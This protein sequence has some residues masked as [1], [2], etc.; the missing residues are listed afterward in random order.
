MCDRHKVSHHINLLSCWGLCAAELQGLGELIVKKWDRSAGGD[1]F[2]WQQMVHS[3][4]LLIYL[5]RL[6][7]TDLTAV[8]F[9]VFFSLNNIHIL[10]THIKKSWANF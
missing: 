8:S 10:D 2:Y 7:P 3:V 5:P 1:S 9:I 6:H 4:E